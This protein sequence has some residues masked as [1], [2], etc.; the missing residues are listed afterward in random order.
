MELC[1]W[2]VAGDESGSAVPDVRL[3]KA[4]NNQT[5]SSDSTRGERLNAV[6][7]WRG[8]AKERAAHPGIQAP[9]PLNYIIIAGVMG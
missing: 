9:A 3:G 4:I 6:A 2:V 1:G 5:R 8:K 7:G